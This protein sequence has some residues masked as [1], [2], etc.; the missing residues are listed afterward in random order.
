M[1]RPALKFQRRWL[2]EDCSDKLPPEIIERADTRGPELAWRVSDIPAVIEAAERASLL[3]LGGDLQFKAPSGALGEPIGMYV[4]TQR[5]P[6]DV[7]WEDQV[8]EAAKVAL[9]DFLSL[10]ER[11]D[12]TKL[13]RE[14]YPTIVAEVTSVGGD[15]GQVVFFRWLVADEEEGKR[16]RTATGFD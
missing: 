12:F 4:D 15:P 7:P 5:V 2:A 8:R 9:A 13:A 10:Q 16:L 14:D 1:E 11:F 6:D 3:N